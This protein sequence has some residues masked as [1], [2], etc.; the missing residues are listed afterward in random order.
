MNPADTLTGVTHLAHRWPVVSPSDAALP[1]VAFVIRTVVGRAGGAEKVLCNVANALADAGI[2]VT[3]YHADPPGRPFF[4]LR[5]SVHVLSVRP[6][7]RPKLPE[8]GSAPRG[9]PKGRA[10]L[11]YRFPASFF[12]WWR[13]HRWFIK[14][15]RSFLRAHRPRLVIAFQPSA[16][17]D[18]LIACMGTGIPVVASLHNVPEHDFTKWER[19]DANPFDRFLRLHALRMAAGITVLLPEFRDWFPPSLQKRMTVLP[20]AVF[21]SGEMARPAEPDPQRNMIIVVGRLSPA[22]DHATLIQAWARLHRAYPDWQ[23]ELYGN[24]PLRKQI[25]AQIAEAGV[26]SSFHLKGESDDVMSHYARA[27]I[28]C[29]PSRFEGFG[30]VTA[31]ALLKGLPAVGFADCP[32]TNSLIVHGSN[33]LLA[34][35]AQYGGD[36]AQALAD[37]LEVLLKNPELRALLGAAGPA[38]MAA[39]APGVVAA[40]WLDLVRRADARQTEDLP[41]SASGNHLEP[42]SRRGE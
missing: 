30:L 26:A 23:I 14:A 25:E 31:E 35:P 6:K 22:K 29:M 34:D 17:T 19:W 28:F 41:A 3:I 5:R 2:P 16:T 24:G 21:V 27:K 36:R 38:S 7:D 32:G 39:F 1:H 40:G 18:T 42:A 20:N 12:T 37:A 10:A 8:T 13:Q 33:G 15:L 11:K 9:A 4:E